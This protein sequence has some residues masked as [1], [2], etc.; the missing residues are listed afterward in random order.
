ME[1]LRVLH[2]VFIVGT[3]IGFSGVM[4]QWLGPPTATDIR[5]GVWI[6][7]DSDER[8]EFHYFDR[9]DYKGTRTEQLHGCRWELNNMQLSIRMSS[10]NLNFVYTMEND[11]R[12]FY[13]STQTFVI[14][15]P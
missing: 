12:T 2:I 3:V 6:S 10:G 11:Y 1:S 5:D 9:C 8:Y 13:S 15:I 14:H 4:F 7:I